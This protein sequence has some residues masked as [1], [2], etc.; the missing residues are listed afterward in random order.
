MLSISGGL[1][2]QLRGYLC[3][4][5]IARIKITETIRGALAVIAGLTPIWGSLWFVD[6]LG[7]YWGWLLSWVIVVIIGGILGARALIRFA[8]RK[9]GPRLPFYLGG[10]G[11]LLGLWDFWF[12]VIGFGSRNAG[13]HSSP[14]IP[15]EDLF[16]FSL[17]GC[18][19]AALF[20][21]FITQRV[22]R[23]GSVILLLLGNFALAVAVLLAA[24]QPGSQL[25][26]QGLQ[27]LVRWLE[28][29]AWTFLLLAGG[30]VGLASDNQMISR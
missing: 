10:I 29:E 15:F 9:W 16:L 4:I 1:L 5:G 28:L 23:I 13:G 20:A 19:I 14:P 12:L 21:A 7:P 24:N 30:F 17:L 3:S 18:S 11:G 26:S 8:I 25:A 6:P 22:V 2:I 27:S